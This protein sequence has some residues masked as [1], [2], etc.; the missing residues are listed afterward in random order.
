MYSDSLDVPIPSLSAGSALVLYT[1]YSR[2]SLW[3]CY[4]YYLG[5]GVVLIV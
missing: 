4:I 1:S 2:G 3:R 5:E